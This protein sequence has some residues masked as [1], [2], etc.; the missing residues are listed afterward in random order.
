MHRHPESS[1]TGSTPEA[2]GACV[3][4]GSYLGT[5]YRPDSNHYSG[6]SCANHNKDTPRNATP[7]SGFPPAERAFLCL[8]PEPH[9]QPSV[10]RIF[11]TPNRQTTVCN[12]SL[13]VR[14]DITDASGLAGRISIAGYTYCTRPTRELGLAYITGRRLV[15]CKRGM[16]YCNTFCNVSC[17]ETQARF[18][19]RMP[20]G[21]LRIA[22]SEGHPDSGLRQGEQLCSLLATPA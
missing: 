16:R 13:P 18:P 15:S 6:V 10:T 5:I 19:Q 3:G 21:T 7:R 1:R 4:D 14:P 9:R 17:I 22:R 12:G 2:G 20:A 8:T 11:S